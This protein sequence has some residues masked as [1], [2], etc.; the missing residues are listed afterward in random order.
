MRRIQERACAKALRGAGKRGSLLGTRG[1]KGHSRT[2]AKENA[3]EQRP[4]KGQGMHKMW[5]SWFS[6]T[7]EAITSLQTTS[8]DSSP[9]RDWHTLCLWTL[10]VKFHKYTQHSI[11]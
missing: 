8:T 9:T 6:T 11:A 7:L 1:R 5:Q 4:R 10:G 3:T 2:A